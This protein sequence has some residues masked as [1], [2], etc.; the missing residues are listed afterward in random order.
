MSLAALEA[1][2]RKLEDVEEI[3]LLK[4][5]YCY[6]VDGGEIDPLMGRF[7][8]DAVWDGGPMGR[9]E[10]RESIRDFMKRLPEQLSFALHWVMNPRIRVD[11]DAATGTWYLVEPHTHAES[12]RALW[13]AGRYDERYVREDDMWKFQE[14]RLTPLFWTPYDQGWGVR[15]SVFEAE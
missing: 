5:D 8:E 13:G 15:P 7:T 3:R 6:A 4:A 12:G 2:V 11:G 14:I 1:R 9:F 10:G